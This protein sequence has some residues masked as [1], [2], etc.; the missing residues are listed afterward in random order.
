MNGLLNHEHSCELDEALDFLNTKEL[1]SGSLT[2]HLETP[3]Q[4]FDWLPARDP[5]HPPPPARERRR[6]LDD[7]ETGQRALARVRRVRDALREVADAVVQH[8]KA[9]PS[10]LAEVN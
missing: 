1:V 3:E 9:A 10:A 4:A 8:R 5:L 6:A 7:P 2:D